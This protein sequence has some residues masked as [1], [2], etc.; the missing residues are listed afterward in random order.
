MK[1]CCRCATG[2]SDDIPDFCKTENYLNLQIQAN[3]FR[4]SL[5]E[6]IKELEADADL[7][8][9]SSFKLFFH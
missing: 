7:V 1:L 4:D 2:E 8:I 9:V 5:H 3:A 6:N